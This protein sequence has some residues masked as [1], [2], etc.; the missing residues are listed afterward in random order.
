MLVFKRKKQ[1]IDNTTTV[2]VG[3]KKEKKKNVGPRIHRYTYGQF[4]TEVTLTISCLTIP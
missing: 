1:R 3:I 2:Y 4:V